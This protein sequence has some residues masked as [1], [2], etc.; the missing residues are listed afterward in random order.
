MPAPE[1][2]ARIVRSNE[3]SLLAMSGIRKDFPGVVALGEVRFELQ[4]GEVHAL[5]GENGAGKSTLGGIHLT[6]VAGRL[7]RWTH[8]APA[9]TIRGP[10]ASSRPG[11]GAM[12][13]AWTTWSGC[14]GRPA[15]P[16]RNV[17]AEGV[18]GWAMAGSCAPAAGAVRR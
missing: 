16:V 8:H 4:S 12:E 1:A 14:D 2:S 5:I 7:A 15:S 10:S 3:A 9:S 18:G 6:G 13:T 17:V 11:S